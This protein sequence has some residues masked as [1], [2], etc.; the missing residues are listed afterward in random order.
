MQHTGVCVLTRY[1]QHRTERSEMLLTADLSWGQGFSAV[2]STFL[3]YLFLSWYK[4][5]HKVSGDSSYFSNY[6]ELL[7]I[8]EGKLN[9]HQI[10]AGHQSPQIRY[11]L[12][13]LLSVSLPN[14]AALGVG[15]VIPEEPPARPCHCPHHCLLGLEGQ[16][17]LLPRAG[18]Q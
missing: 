10:R 7:Q 4:V 13:K 1:Q 11:F 12:S 17:E 8:I 16:V 2:L 9:F 18:E 15:S 6:P 14:P 5:K 3:H